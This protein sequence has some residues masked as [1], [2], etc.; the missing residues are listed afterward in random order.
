MRPNGKGESLRKERRRAIPG[1]DEEDRRG[2][3]LRERVR[4]AHSS[5]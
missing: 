4:V 2:E 1:F 5:L 3:V